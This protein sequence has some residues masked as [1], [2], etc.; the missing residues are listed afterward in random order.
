MA[1]GQE[2][3]GE[4]AQQK[5]DAHKVLNE[6]HEDA[7]KKL[8][9]A[10]DERAAQGETDEIALAT[11]R[12]TLPK[13]LKDEVLKK[14]YD[15]YRERLENASI[16]QRQNLMGQLSPYDQILE[17][18]DTEANNF[19]DTITIVINL[20]AQKGGDKKK[21]EVNEIAELSKILEDVN[22]LMK[23]D[24][25]FQ[26]ILKKLD[27]DA[28][29]N[30]QL[31][32]SDYQKIAEMWLEGEKAKSNGTSPNESKINQTNARI[33]VKLM[34]PQQRMDFVREMMDS[35]AKAVDAIDELLTNNQITLR[36]GEL[37]F[38][39]A[40]NKGLIDSDQLVNFQKDLQAKYPGLQEKFKADE[41]KATEALRGQ[42]SN[43]V[44]NRGTQLVGMVM[45]AHGVLW[46]ATNLLASGGDFNRILQNPYLALSAAEVLAGRYISKY[47]SKIGTSYAGLGPL[48]EY[49]S[50]SDKPKNP[51]QEEAVIKL[52]EQYSNNL[53]FGNYLKNGGAQAII[54]LNN[55]HALNKNHAP[56]TYAELIEKAGQN[57]EQLSSFEAAKKFSGSGKAGEIEVE[58]QITEFIK[59]SLTLEI[60]NQP[61]FDH[62]IELIEKG[63]GLKGRKPII[64]VVEQDPNAPK[65]A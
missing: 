9:D 52:S 11:L 5:V 43:N 64:E 25:Q 24:K 37:L 13:K 17:E 10:F 61:I 7:N 36:Q 48:F 2:H 6:K 60:S 42:Y 31:V 20:E 16:S 34:D 33:L 54:D 28:L 55:D 27:P 51:E 57:R 26:Q 62:K 38:S 30:K 23:E 53:D 4:Q 45:G 3:S 8:Q 32:P 15:K 1:I 14:I 49:F 19:I 47:G 18:A 65:A 50:E 63:Q 29:D 46:F 21:L 22:A 40:F 35:K 44:F 39:E 59:N 56:V 58:K 41:E 12:E